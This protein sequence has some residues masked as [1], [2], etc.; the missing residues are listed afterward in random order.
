MREAGG[1]RLKIRGCGHGLRCD[2]ETRKIRGGE[3]PEPIRSAR[4]LTPHFGRSCWRRHRRPGGAG[5]PHL[6]SRRRCI[7][8]CQPI[9]WTWSSGRDA[10]TAIRDTRCVET[11]PGGT[12]R[13][14]RTIPRVIRGRSFSTLQERVGRCIGAYAI[15]GVHGRRRRDHRAAMFPL[16]LSAARPTSCPL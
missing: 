11:L 5:F 4:R 1:S 6:L 2:S 8:T 16:S 9:P 13:D 14:W 15:L 3:F 12:Q 10:F 7:G